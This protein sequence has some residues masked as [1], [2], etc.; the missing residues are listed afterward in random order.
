MQHAAPFLINQAGSRS[1][2]PAFHGFI[3]PDL[4]PGLSFPI[5]VGSSFRLAPMIIA[6]HVRP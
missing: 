4:F 1:A 5:G 6:I 3:V 2:E